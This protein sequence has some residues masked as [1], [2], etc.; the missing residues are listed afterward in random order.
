MP[1][2]T[3]PS[4]PVVTMNTPR[5]P[6][7]SGE[8]DKGAQQLRREGS[9]LKA[10]VAELET[11][12][13]QADE[14][15]AAKDVQLHAAVAAG[16]GS[17]PPREVLNVKEQLRAKEKEIGNL[18]DELLEMEKLAVDAQEK[19][20]TYKTQTQA[21]LDEMKAKD[22]EIATLQART[23]ALTDDCAALE[24]QLESATSQANAERDDARNALKTEQAAKEQAKKAAVA[25]VAL[26]S[27]E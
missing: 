17:T 20:D 14:S 5:S 4:P 18:K 13:K 19:L 21:K 23:K 26:L 27:D 3:P 7:S 2:S 11:R 8:M 24:Q 6:S 12:L 16:G 25:L 1:V 10:K 9:E 22:V 15:L